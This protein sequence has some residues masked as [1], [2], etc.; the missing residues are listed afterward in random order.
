MTAHGHKVTLGAPE[1]TSED[2]V[3]ECSCS[4]RGSVH[5]TW[6]AAADEGVDHIRVARRLRSVRVARDAEAMRTG[7][8]RRRQFR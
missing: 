6:R 8:R 5:G 7:L 3:A 1:P 2:W 4:W